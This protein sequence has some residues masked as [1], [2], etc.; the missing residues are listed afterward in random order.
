[1]LSGMLT[2]MGNTECLPVVG[3]LCAKM[4]E[5]TG[6]GWGDGSG[7]KGSWTTGS[8]VLCQ[9]TRIGFPNRVRVRTHPRHF[10]VLSN[11]ISSALEDNLDERHIPVTFCHEFVRRLP[12]DRQGKY[13][14]LQ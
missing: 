3:L 14:E 4:L 13:T 1:M 11:V 10:F 7:R 6:D 5:I 2:N 8:V 12:L 9:H